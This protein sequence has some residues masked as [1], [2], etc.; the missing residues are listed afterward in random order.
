MRYRQLLDASKT[1]LAA[2][3]GSLPNTAPSTQIFAL[4]AR[5]MYDRLLELG[6]QKP[7]NA[8]APYTGYGLLKYGICGIASIACLICLGPLAIPLS[9][10]VFY[11]LEVHFLFLFPLLIDSSPHPIRSSIRSAYKIGIG[12]CFITVI[13][14][15]VYMMTGL[16]RKTNR[17]E[18]WYIGCLAIVIWYNNEIRN[19][20]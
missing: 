6:N 13:P 7:F 20:I 9:I 19:R 2:V 3:P 8:R 1:H 11:L 5:W 17:L 12:Q 14:I 16:F 18:N 15:A 10:A 4:G